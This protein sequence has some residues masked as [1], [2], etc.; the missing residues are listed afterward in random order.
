MTAAISLFTGHSALGKAIS[1]NFDSTLRKVALANSV[2]VVAMVK[3]ATAEALAQLL[4]DC[5]VSHALALG[6]CSRDRARVVIADKQAAVAGAVA[7]TKDHFKFA[8]GH[9]WALLDIDVK[10]APLILLPS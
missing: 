4:D 3:V 5:E 2:C 10:D 8:P 6:T 7:R 1:V 9:G